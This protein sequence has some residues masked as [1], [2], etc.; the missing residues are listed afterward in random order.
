MSGALAIVA[1]ALA[2]FSLYAAHQSGDDETRRD[3]T[4]AILLVIS[5]V[6]ALLALVLAYVA[7]R[8]A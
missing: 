3:G 4:H 7:G 1:T 6:A 8:A 5:A 2:A